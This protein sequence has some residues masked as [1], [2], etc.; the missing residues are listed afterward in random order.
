MQILILLGQKFSHSTMH[1]S[2]LEVTQTA[3]VYTAH[4][5]RNIQVVFTL[6]ILSTVLTLKDQPQV[7]ILTRDVLQNKAVGPLDS[8]I[9]STIITI[10]DHTVKGVQDILQ[11]L[12]LTTMKVVTQC[13][14]TLHILPASL[15]IPA[16]RL[17]LG[18]T[19]VHILL[20]NSNGL[21]SNRLHKTITE[22]LFVHHIPRH[23]QGLARVHHHHTSLRTTNVHHKL[24]QNPS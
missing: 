16:H 22:I 1:R 19:L 11:E 14:Q 6:L 5:R 23:G 7:P 8:H 3:T 21:Q 10:L 13:L 12:T 24:D 4:L 9:L 15:F 2:C 18:H 20:H 17:K